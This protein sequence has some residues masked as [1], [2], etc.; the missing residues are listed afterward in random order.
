MDDFLGVLWAFVD[1]HLGELLTFTVSFCAIFTS[2]KC[3]K[4]GMRAEIEKA[5]VLRK[6]ECLED[7]L[8]E[9]IE[10]DASRWRKFY[11]DMM[12]VLLETKVFAPLFNGGKFTTNRK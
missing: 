9:V 1:A 4:R 3:I 11:S 5:L 12:K 10:S 2:W 8:A 6:L 7:A